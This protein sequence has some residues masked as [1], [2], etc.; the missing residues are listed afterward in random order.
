MDLG[1]FEDYLAKSTHETVLI[2]TATALFKITQKPYLI[3]IG[4]VVKQKKTYFYKGSLLLN[5]VSSLCHAH[6]SSPFSLSSSTTTMS[7]LHFVCFPNSILCCRFL[8]FF[9]LFPLFLIL[10]TN[11]KWCSAFVM[12]MGR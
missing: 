8:F 9:F 5:G 2:I 3:T 1:T 7:L 4:K 11:N 10:S 12:R 6:V